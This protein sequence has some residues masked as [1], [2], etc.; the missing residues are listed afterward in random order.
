M[1]PRYTHP[2]GPSDG[3]KRRAR[4]RIVEL[5]A[6]VG[7]PEARAILAD[8]GDGP[9]NNM[10]DAVAA[11]EAARK[12]LMARQPRRTIAYHIADR[13]QVGV[14]TAYRRI[15]DAMSEPF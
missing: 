1:D 11:T 14:S 15:E 6:S 5:I 2:E 3:K 13:Y 8:I 4:Q 10:F 7:E 9:A 12:M